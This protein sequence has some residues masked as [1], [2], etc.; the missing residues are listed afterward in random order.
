MSPAA[1]AVELDLNCP[2]FQRQLLALPKEGQWAVLR[3]LGR[4]AAMSWHEIYA[5][6]GLRW[7]VI[8]SRPGPGGGRL[9]SLR[10]SQRFR[11]VACRDGNCLR[12]LSLHSDH[13]PAYGR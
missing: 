11:A 12:L 9:Y 8:L 5:D 3:T 13:D 10:I 2:V 1:G 4:L 6:P 7:E